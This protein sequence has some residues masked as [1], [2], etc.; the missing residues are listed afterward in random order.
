MIKCLVIAFLFT[1][2][3]AVKAGDV[4]NPDQICGKW[5][6]SDKK[7]VIEVYKES[8]ELKA[9][10]LWFRSGPDEPCTSCLDSNNPD[11][12]LR[13]RKIVGINVLKDMRYNAGTQ[14]WEDGM[15]YDA[16]NG[17]NWNASA[18]MDADGSLKV[19]G[20][21]H[22]K[23]IGKTMTFNRVNDPAELAKR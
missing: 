12:L 8:N 18:K 4:S 17:R 15:I 21:W 16:H 6:S 20:Y 19:K 10:I 7:L 11:P 1:F 9:K 14:S 5:V 13:K 22:F 23:F 3:S 2:V